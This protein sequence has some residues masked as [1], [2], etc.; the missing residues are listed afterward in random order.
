ML[1]NPAKWVVV[2]LVLS[3]PD[4]LE[5][6]PP[7]AGVGAGNRTGPPVKATRALHGQGISADHFFF[8]MMD[9]F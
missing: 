2:G 6:G 8:L 1:E 4:S 7:L 5:L 9:I 3:P